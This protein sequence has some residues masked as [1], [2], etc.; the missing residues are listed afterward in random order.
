MSSTSY[1]LFVLEDVERF[2]DVNM[3][4]VEIFNKMQSKD[5]Y[6]NLYINTLQNKYK[7]SVIKILYSTFKID[8][9]KISTTFFFISQ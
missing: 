2:S 4:Y 9:F 5:L 1:N 7:I 3:L 8:T 6:K